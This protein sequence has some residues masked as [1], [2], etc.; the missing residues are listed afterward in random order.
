MTYP[1]PLPKRK[2]A[3]LMAINRASIPTTRHIVKDI[4]F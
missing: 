3:M 4:K 1:I 2:I